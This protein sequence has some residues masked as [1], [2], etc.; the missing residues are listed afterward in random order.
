MV[1]QLMDCASSTETMGTMMEWERV[2][3]GHG[4][5]AMWMASEGSKGTMD[6]GWPSFV[7]A[8]GL[9]RETDQMAQQ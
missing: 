6:Y 1:T 8:Y 7:G 5:P 2:K 4:A 9:D 3:G